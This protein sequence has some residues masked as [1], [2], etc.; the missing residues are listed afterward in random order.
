[1][2]E[3]SD[4]IMKIAA[5]YGLILGFVLV[6]LEIVSNIFKVQLLF[7]IFFSFAGGIFYATTVYREKYLGGNIS[8]N[9]SLLFGVLLSGFSFILLGMYAY[10]YIF[11]NPNEFK[12]LFDIVVQNMKE[13]GIS[14]SEIPD[15]PN[16]NPLM[17]IIS[18]TFLGLIFGLI[19]SS[20]T[21]I[22]TKKD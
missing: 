1:M 9:K 20:V 22:F 17:V 19:I 16:I 15:N 2:T 21:S 6:A 4:K 3:N 18:Y 10:M 11:L 14:V 12:E 13:K 5:S 8:Y 7:V